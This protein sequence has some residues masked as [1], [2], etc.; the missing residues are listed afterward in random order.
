MYQLKASRL[1]PVNAL[2]Y[3][4][5]TPVHHSNEDING[6]S[7]IDRRQTRPVVRVP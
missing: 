6:L 3:L 5:C 2:P 1:E 4:S 7:Q